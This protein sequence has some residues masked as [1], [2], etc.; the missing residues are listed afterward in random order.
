MTVCASSGWRSVP[1]HSRGGEAGGSSDS[2]SVACSSGDGHVLGARDRRR[3]PAPPGLD[4]VDAGRGELQPLEHASGGKEHGRAVDAGVEVGHSR[5]DPGGRSRGS[6]PEDA[7]GLSF[8]GLR[9]LRLR[10]ARAGEA[11]PQPVVASAR[12]GQ[13]VGDLRHRRGGAHRLLSTFAED[14]DPLAL[15]V[16]VRAIGAAVL[17][18]ERREDLRGL[19]GETGFQEVEGPHDHARPLGVRDRARPDVAVEGKEA[20]GRYPADEGEGAYGA[21]YRASRAAH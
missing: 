20:G 2:W 8:P 17:A 6:D 10:L 18:G 16:A 7:E 5:F 1:C 11:K 19:V 3:P 13:R 9:D 15:H 4:G 14:L 21:R 12:D